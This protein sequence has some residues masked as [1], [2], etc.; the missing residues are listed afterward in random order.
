MIDYPS[1][2]AFS[3]HYSLSNCGLMGGSKKILMKADEYMAKN[4]MRQYKEFAVRNGVY[5]TKCT[6][7]TQ[8]LQA[9]EK[10]IFS[11]ES[12]FR[13]AQK[14]VNVRMRERYDARKKAF[15]AANGCSAE[16][17]KFKNLPM[18]ARVYVS[19]RNEAM[20]TCTRYVAP[21]SIAENYMTNSVMNQVRMASCPY[22]EYLMGNCTEGYVKGQ[23]EERRVAVLASE[24]RAGQ[25]S[26]SEAT[27]LQ[28]KAPQ[29]AVQNYG[30][31]CSHEEKQFYEMPAVAAAMMR[32]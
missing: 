27:R 24:Y 8:K 25:Q 18:S 7:G 23:A 17:S 26:A 5:T 19:A 11:R 9:D 14:P 31:E 10:R 30:H 6:E 21:Q 13:Q 12:A 4:I 2:P 22:G 3:G 1:S 32:D 15:I 16:E 29:A 28:Y 20:G